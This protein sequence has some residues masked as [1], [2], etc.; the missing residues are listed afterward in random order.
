MKGEAPPPTS[1]ADLLP[2]SVRR[3]SGLSPRSSGTAAHARRTRA[4]SFDA[5][6]SFEQADPE[7]LER[8]E[9]LRAARSQLAHDRQLP[10]FCVCSD[11][12]L[13]LIARHSPSDL[14]SLEQVKGMGPMKVKMYG[15]ILLN[16]MRSSAS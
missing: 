11:R 9:R 12:T 13:K 15:D 10:A 16:A 14:Q 6:D 2:R 7:T 4:E 8:F 3:A 5:D 1:L